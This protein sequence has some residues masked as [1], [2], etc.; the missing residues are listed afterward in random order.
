[1]FELGLFFAVTLGVLGII[2]LHDAYGDANAHAGEAR[3]ENM[4]QNI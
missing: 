1:M 4:R 2:E 3:A